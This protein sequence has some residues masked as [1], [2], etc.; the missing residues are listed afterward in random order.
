MRRTNP[1]SRN[2]S[3]RLS[4]SAE[5]RA[6]RAACQIGSHQTELACRHGTD[7]PVL[8]PTTEC[9][10]CQFGRTAQ[11]FFWVLL[12]RPANLA[13]KRGEFFCVL[14]MSLLKTIS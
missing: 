1:P 8:I 12:V 11:W 3:V 7:H 4:V 6:N 2:F 10:A 14:N 9:R 13:G 5:C